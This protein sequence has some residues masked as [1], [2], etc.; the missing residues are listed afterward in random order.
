MLLIQFFKFPN[1][2][3]NA[4]V[5]G[6]GLRLQFALGGSMDVGVS[7]TPYHNYKRINITP[8]DG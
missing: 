5:Q 8:G 4:P 1:L 7:H 6:L 2:F 3:I